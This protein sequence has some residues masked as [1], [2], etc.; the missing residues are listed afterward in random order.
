M[1]TTLAPLLHTVALEGTPSKPWKNAGGS[2]RELLAWP[3]ADA[4][5]W[6]IS[7]ADISRPGPF[8][9]FAGV[10]RGFAVLEGAGVVLQVHGQA[11]RMSPD[12][13]PLHFDGAAPPGCT[14]KE[15]PVRVL[16]VM[17][18][19]GAGDSRMQRARV[20]QPWR[21]K[22]PLRA[23]LSLQPSKL[24]VDDAPPRELPAGTLAWCDQPGGEHWLWQPQAAGARAWW[25]SFTP[26]PR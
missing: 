18:R 12:S 26:S 4:W 17:T 23:L 9:A 16:N 22:A 19:Q 5:D 20:G 1:M 14:L 7:V 13:E 11:L 21:S 2:T 3:R 25:L 10:L 6:R 15:G 8:S 24:I